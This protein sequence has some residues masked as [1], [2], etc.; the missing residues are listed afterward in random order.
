MAVQQHLDELLAERADLVKQ[1]L[2]QKPRKVEAPNKGSAGQAPETDEQLRDD[3]LRELRGLT[4]SKIKAYEPK[5]AVR[6]EGGK[7]GFK[8]RLGTDHPGIFGTRREAEQG[9]L[10]HLDLMWKQYENPS[11]YINIES[12][13]AIKRLHVIKREEAA[14]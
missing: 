11:A 13:R 6:K 7:W 1:V 8:T 12:E 10:A 9:A 3:Y 4:E 5:S 2:E 14:S